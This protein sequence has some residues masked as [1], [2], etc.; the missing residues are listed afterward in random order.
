MIALT[1]VQKLLDK[2]FP[3]IISGHIGHLCLAQALNTH[4]VLTVDPVYIRKLLKQEGLVNKLIQAVD[5]RVGLFNMNH[6]HIFN[7]IKAS[8]R[9][10]FHFPVNIGSAHADVQIRAVFQNIV[11]AL[12]LIV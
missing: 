4:I 6:S 12:H 1:A 7:G 9:K 5:L 3:R 11:N 2:I 8:D 10:C